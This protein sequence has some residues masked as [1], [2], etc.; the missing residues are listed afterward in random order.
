MCFPSTSTSQFITAGSQGRRSSGK[1]PEARIEA[2]AMLTLLTGSTAYWL[3]LLY[4]S[5]PPAPKRCGAI[6]IGWA[7]PHQSPIKKMPEGLPTGQ[8][9]GIVFF[10]S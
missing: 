6:R 5:G 8:S 2:E 10:L 1:N 7:L 3:L 4:S 9:G